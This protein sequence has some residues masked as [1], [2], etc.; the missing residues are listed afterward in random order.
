MIVVTGATGNV[1]RPLVEALLAA[2]EPVT[3]VSRGAAELPEGAVHVR[4]DLAEPA[5]LKAAFEGADRLF[6]LTRDQGLDLA[7]VLE[8]A[9]AAGIVRVV[10]LSSQRAVTRDD[11]SQQALEAA[12]TESGLEWT[13]LRPSGFHSNAFLWA[14]PVRTARAIAAPFGDVGLPFIDPADIAAV[15]AKALT[16]D[17]HAGRRYTLTGPAP[18]SPREQAA[19]IGAAI[20]EPVAFEELTRDEAFARFTRF[21]PAEV[22]EG[23]LETLGNPTEAEREVGG[24]VERLLGRPPVAFATWAERNA[25][26]FR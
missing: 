25:A 16:E 21:W 24:E 1:G 26:A 8:V 5:T 7:P 20:G 13:I 19:A 2:G 18:V 10:L 14:E 11:R 22:V 9:A 15:A 3:A 17:G 4:A 12:V 6:L 23:A